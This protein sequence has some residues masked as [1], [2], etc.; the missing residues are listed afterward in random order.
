MGRQAS[1]DIDVNL[2]IDSAVNRYKSDFRFRDSIYW[3]KEKNTKSSGF[4]DSAERYNF[5]LVIFIH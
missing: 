1:Q 3:R 4:A 5:I 2:S